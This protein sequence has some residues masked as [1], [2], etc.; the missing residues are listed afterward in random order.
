MN[1]LQSSSELP[2][3]EADE[4]FK[5]YAIPVSTLPRRGLGDR[6]Y[7]GCEI[8]VAALALLTTLPIMLLVALMVRRDSPGPILFVQDR[9]ARSRIVRGCELQARDDIQAPGGSFEPDT[10]YYVPG[11]FPFVKFRT[12]YEDARERFPHLYDYEYMKVHHGGM[13]RLEEDPRVT[14]VGRRLRQLTLDELPNF[15]NVLTG[16]MTLVGPRPEV[17]YVLS[18]YSPEQMIK[19]SVKPGVTGLAQ[20]NGRARLSLQEVVAWD[21]K[22]IQERKNAWYDIKIMLRTVWLVLAR[23]GAF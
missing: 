22:Y 6:L 5:P 4:P 11:T 3:V 15:W 23:R 20:T 1:P 16:D 12:M 10:L 19:F 9:L 13:Y 21:L 2:R 14:R 18:G 17:P 7:R 8:I